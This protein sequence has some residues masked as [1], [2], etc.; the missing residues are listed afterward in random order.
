MKY[1]GIDFG[2]RRVGIASSDDEG[3]LAFPFCVIE[4][5]PSLEKDIMA[6]V[7]KENVEALV[8]GKSVTPQGKNNPVQ[9]EI[10]DFVAR[11]SL[12]Y[13]IPIHFEQE[14]FT[15]FEAR[16]NLNPQ[17]NVANPRRSARSQKK[18]DSAAAIILQRYLDSH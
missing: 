11:F 16:R 6:I 3:R 13:P 14:A 10:E 2:T 9:T 1:L 8:I 5:S 4:N 7:E 12:L 18:D 15:S 17:K